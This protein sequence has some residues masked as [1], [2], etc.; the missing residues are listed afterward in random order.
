MPDASDDIEKTEDI[1]N[2]DNSENA[3]DLKQTDKHD[4]PENSSKQMFA[5]ETQETAD[6]SKQNG[7]IEGN[8][9]AETVITT[10]R[11]NVRTAAS[12][13]SDI[14]RV[15]EMNMEVQRLSDDGEWSRILLDQNE[16]FI[17]SRYLKVQDREADGVDIAGNIQNDGQSDIQ[18]DAQSN[19]QD[20]GNAA[21]QAA[22][23][24]RLVVIDAG[25]QSKADTS[26]EPVGPGASESKAK[27]AGGTSGVSTGMG[28]FELNLEVALKLK[29]ELISRGYRV[30]MCRESN[31]VNISNSERAQ[32][33]N[34]NNADAFI[35]IHAN[36]ST[37]S[38]V[39]GMMTICQT[40][41]NPYNA[42]LYSKS[43]SLS[44]YVLDEMV[45]STG[46]KKEYVWETD[47]MSGIN[48]C[49]VPVTIV[50]MGY[51]TNAAEDERMATADYQYKIVD[52]IANGI[53]KFLAE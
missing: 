38:S 3:D 51:M 36:G 28:E 12:T 31:D 37:N 53:D 1:G 17:A 39:N 42:S 29:D 24:G 30:I 16:Y 23:D 22:G 25:H 43:K 34:E 26:T 15:L 5:T 41:S 44:T 35:R 14:Y 45:S 18:S 11:V 6:D 13:E 7:E 8:P 52:G 4:E 2:V 19:I 9:V 40:A 27:V 33:A 20:D 46:A 21:A 47:T 32:I 49:Q 48:W 10:D 50:E